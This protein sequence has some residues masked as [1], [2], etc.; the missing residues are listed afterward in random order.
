MRRATKLRVPTEQQVSE[1]ESSSRLAFEA[2]AF[3]LSAPLVAHAAEKFHVTYPLAADDHEGVSASYQVFALPTMIVI[4][5]KGNVKEI[6]I[7]DTE[8]VDAAVNAAL[9][10]K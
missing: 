10:A 5:R 1:I 6:A 3:Y 2:G 7:S 8:A 4:D 9:K